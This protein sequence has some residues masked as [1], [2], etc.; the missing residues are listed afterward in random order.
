AAGVNGR[1][2]GSRPHRARRRRR[3]HHRY[4]A[5]RLCP[6]PRTATTHNRIAATHKGPRRLVPS[7]FPGPGRAASRHMGQ[8]RGVLD[9]YPENKAREITMDN[10]L[11]YTNSEI[12]QKFVKHLNSASAAVPQGT[13]PVATM[14]LVLTRASQINGCAVCVDM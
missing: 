6:P 9:M 2:L 13:L 1:C 8:P 4:P 7:C 11:D 5:G 12:L 14:N 3:A 10:R